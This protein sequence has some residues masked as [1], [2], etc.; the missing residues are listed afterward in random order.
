VQSIAG[1]RSELP[2][3]TLEPQLEQMLTDATQATDAGP[4]IEPGLA[5]RMQQAI[6]D[7]A[8][9]QEMAG[10]PA[11]LLVAPKL[12]PWLARF[13]RHVAPG[14]AVLAYNEIPENRRIRVVAAVGR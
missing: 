1:L 8:R 10:E 9:R 2:V 14:L 6:A 3:I 5:E 4:G 13:M 11:V 12:R 7:S